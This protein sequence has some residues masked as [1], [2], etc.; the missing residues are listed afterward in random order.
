MKITLLSLLILIVSCTYPN[1]N[2]MD[3]NKKLEYKPEKIDLNNHSF[4]SGKVYSLDIEEL[5]SIIKLG[6]EYKILFFNQIWCE[7]NVNAMECL[8]KKDLKEFDLIF[9]SGL[10][11]IFTKQYKSYLKDSE[12]K[13]NM[14]L[15]D[16]EKYPIQSGLSIGQSTLKKDK[17]F[18]KDFFDKE[19]YKEFENEESFPLLIVID[20]NKNV[21]YKSN[22]IGCENSD[23]NSLYDKVLNQIRN[24]IN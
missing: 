2:E 4:T 15:I 9:I 11:W 23:C 18:L 21:I 6:K 24:N 14:Y 7:T 17:S 1:Y 16:L 10:D 12:I 8:I 3:E 5:N 20:K 22:E 19:T 13:N